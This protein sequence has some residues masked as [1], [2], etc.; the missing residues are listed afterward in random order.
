M[1]TIERPMFITVHGIDGTGK[2]T[3]TEVITKC[4]ESLNI[5]SINY[6][7]F[8]QSNISNPFAVAKKRV[9]LEAS[10]FAQ[11]AFFL[12]STL[13][14]SDQINGLLRDGYSVIKSR[15][16][17]DVLAH[18]AYL[19]VEDTQGVSNAF[20]IKR[21]DLKIL[22]TLNEEERKRRII[23]RGIFDQKDKD[24]RD[25]K[26]RLDF[27]EDYLL[28]IMGENEHSLAA[29]NVDTLNLTPQQIA[30]L[31]IENLMTRRLIQ[32]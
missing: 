19:G 15:Y 7:V 22:L 10:P 28:K 2:T 3:T 11:L 1:A 9:V 23:T 29:M 17:D 20:P 24:V 25:G 26:S 13:Y 18:H 6:D 21:P 31:V 5:A 12:G 4:L 14:H 30:S 32:I 8:E 16:L 27:F